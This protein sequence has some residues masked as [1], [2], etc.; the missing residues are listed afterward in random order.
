M[1]GHLEQA[2]GETVREF[3]AE[4][5]PAALAQAPAAPMFAAPGP[6]RSCPAA[7]E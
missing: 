2:D 1:A 5:A 4:M 6:E 3:V 7:D